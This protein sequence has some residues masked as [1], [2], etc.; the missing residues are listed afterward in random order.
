LFLVWKTGLLES[1]RGLLHKQTR[2][3]PGLAGGWWGDQIEKATEVTDLAVET[4]IGRTAV[5]PVWNQMKH[6]AALAFETRR[7]GEQIIRS[8][9]QLAD[10]WGEQLEIHLVGHSAGAILLGHMLQGL[11]YRKVPMEKIHSIHLFAPACSVAFANQH[12]GFSP[13]T[14]QRLHLSLLSDPLERA[15]SVAGI[16]RKSLLYLVSGA[17][18]TDLRTPIAGMAKVY[19][20]DLGGLDSGWDGSSTTNESLRVW[21]RSVKAAKLQAT[22]RFNVVK[23]A[24]LCTAALPGAAKVMAPADHGSFDNSIATLTRT[25]EVVRGGPLLQAVDDLRGF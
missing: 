5:L 11:V 18:E 9:Q 24:T 15:D 17:L 20:E 1:I 13:E 21:R 8:L 2:Q 23:E 7:G 4:H 6:V 12:Y 16:Y 22:G 10:T 19:Q 3:E 14:M 25:L